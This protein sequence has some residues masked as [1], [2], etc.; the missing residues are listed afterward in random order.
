MLEKSAF[1][2]GQGPPTPVNS[3]SF[4]SMSL[5]STRPPCY[6]RSSR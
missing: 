5:T 6:T 2:D 3:A 4:G 1:Q